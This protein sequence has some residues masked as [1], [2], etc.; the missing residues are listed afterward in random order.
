MKVNG[1]VSIIITLFRNIKGLGS[2]RKLD[3][4]F[5]TYSLYL[6]IANHISKVFVE[7]AVGS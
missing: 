4:N 1:K 6:M 5:F 7:L 3:E 2:M